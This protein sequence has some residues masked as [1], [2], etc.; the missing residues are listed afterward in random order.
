MKSATGRCVHRASP[1][2]S[3]GQ[4]IML[5]GLISSI[6][7]RH[8][9]VCHRHVCGVTLRVSQGRV[10]I[11]DRCM[12]VGHNKQLGVLQADEV[13]AKHD[14]NYM[15]PEVAE[16]LQKSGKMPMPSKEEFNK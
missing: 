13:L 16:A 2:R 8:R 14:E 3:S 5:T 7:H 9:G 12:H 10:S 11:I 4:S 6:E 1:V 15:P